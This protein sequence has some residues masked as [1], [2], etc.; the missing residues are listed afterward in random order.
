MSYNCQNLFDDVDQGT[1]YAEY[2]PSSGEWT[3]DCYLAKLASVAAAVRKAPLKPDLLLLQEIE[4]GAVVQKLCDEFLPFGGYEF[5]AAPAVD[6]AAVRTAVASRVPVTDL[7]VHRPGGGEGER[8]ILE[9]R[10]EVEGEAIVCFNNHWKSRLG[11]EE[12]TEP[13]RIRA[14]RLVLRRLNELWVSEPE[15]PVVIA[16]DLNED[17]FATSPG[18]PTALA[19]VAAARAADA[20]LRFMPGGDPERPA[21][22]LLRSGWNSGEGNG[23]YYYAGRWQRIDHFFWNGALED[24]RGWEA[25]RMQVLDDPLLLENGIPHSFDAAAMDGYSDHL[26]LL[27]E[28]TLAE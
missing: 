3:R 13:E 23:S 26:P 24:G 20:V 21:F 12:E 27:L 14:A 4:N 2:D 19:P 11:G 1:E 16:G 7:R 28:L 18:F 5:I 10:I 22:P 8:N 15:L 17:P 9:F 6:G 25:V